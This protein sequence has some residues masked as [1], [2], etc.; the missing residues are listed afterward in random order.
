MAYYR[1]HRPIQFR[2]LLGQANAVAALSGALA[3]HRLGHAYLF[4]G[5]R[6]TGKT[7]AARIFARAICCTNLQTGKDRTVEPCGTCSS[8]QAILSNTATDL[9]EIDA[10]SNRGIED[11]RELREQAMYPPI[12]LSHRVYIIDEVHMLTTEAFNALLKTLEEPA[13]HVVFILA[14]TE[15]HKVP[16]TIR[17][18]CQLIRFERASEED[19]TKKLLQITKQEKLSADQESLARIAHHAQGGFRDAETL[20]EKLANQHPVLTKQ[21]VEESLGLL[22]EDVTEALLTAA[23]AGNT[24]ECLD[25]LHANCQ[26]LPNLDAVIARL[27]E[28]VRSRI[29]QASTTSKTV[30]YRLISALDQL[31]EA[32]ILQKSAPLPLVALE[33]ALLEICSFDSQKDIHRPSRQEVK[34]A[35]VSPS[36]TPPKHIAIPSLAPTAATTPLTETTPAESELSGEKMADIRKAWK[37]VIEEISR[38]NLFLGQLLRQATFHTASESSISIHVRYTFH[39]DKLAEKKNQQ[40]IQAILK[41]LTG[42]TWNLHY[43]V[44]D[45]VPRSKAVKRPTTNLDDAVAVFGTGPT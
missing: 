40:R 45:A 31:L 2:D 36:P 34:Q 20:L 39:V 28:D 13:V 3:M 29:H 18:R 1:T 22:P 9:I 43:T 19:L 33:L 37:E 5:P 7:S 8:C 26:A 30:D 41:R 16:T 15:L 38:D 24:S 25:L 6:G 42:Q 21:I 23:L 11:I 12:Q 35:P 44:N 4:S 27:I 10:A 17:S 14:T 32:Y